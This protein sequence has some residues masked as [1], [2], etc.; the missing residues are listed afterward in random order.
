MKTLYAR[1][2]KIRDAIPQL[3]RDVEYA[4]DELEDYRR[5]VE[6]QDYARATRA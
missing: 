2:D 4:E 6:R 5:D 1:R 3:A